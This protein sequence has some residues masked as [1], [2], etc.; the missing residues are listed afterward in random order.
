MPAPPACNEASQSAKLARKHQEK[1][2]ADEAAQEDELFQ[3]IGFENR[4]GTEIETEAA[5]AT[6]PEPE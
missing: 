2:D 4:L 3:R 6:R 1:R 5:T